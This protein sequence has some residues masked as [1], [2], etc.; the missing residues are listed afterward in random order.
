MSTIFSILRALQ[1]NSSPSVL[2]RL[3][4]AGT[5]VFLLYKA[6]SWIVRNYSSPLRSLPGPPNPHFFWGH[7]K[8]I[9]Q[10]DQSALQQ[11]WVEKYGPTISYNGL[12]ST[13]VLWTMDTRALNHILTNTYTYQRPRQTR[14]HMAQLI[15]QGVLVAEEDQHSNQRRALNPAFSSAA[16]RE[17]TEIFIEKSQMLRDRWLDEIAKSDKGDAHVDVLSWLGKASL[18]MIGQAGF[19]YNFNAIYAKEGE[20]EVNDAFN[21]VSISMHTPRLRAIFQAFFPFLRIFKTAGERNLELAQANMRRLGLQLIS[22]KKASV[23][24]A[25]KESN[26]GK[27]EL[28]G[29]DVLTLLV[30]ANMS[31]DVPESRRLSDEEV[32]AQFPT[33]VVAGHDTTATATTWALFSLT[34]HPEIQ[35][36]LRE[37]LLTVP[38]ENPTMAELHALPYL[39]MFVKEVLRYHS[40]V[41]QSTRVATKDDIIPCSTPYTDRHGVQRN[42]IHIQKGDMVMIPIHALD[43]YKP[44]WGEDAGE[45]KPERWENLPDAVKAVPGVYGNLLSFLGGPRACIGYRFSLAELK[46]VL[47]T[48]VREFEFELDVAADRVKKRTAVVQRAIVVGDESEKKSQGRMPIIVRQHVRA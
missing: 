42:H 1:V 20:C 15:G 26:V 28:L 46:A 41:P 7:A 13:R 24:A 4:T 9:Y 35:R 33:L 34:Q 11:Q 19:D 3:F 23:I 44:Y 47:F 38:T 21:T 2:A 45:F 10:A 40:I 22:E 37:E 18:D 32:L 14:Y 29:R 30:K 16:V 27:K 36:K 8:S 43:R 12:F 6:G 17:M 5:F 25:S 48:L 39:G 31:S